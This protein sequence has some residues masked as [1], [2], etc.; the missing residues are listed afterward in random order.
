MSQ[1]QKKA[2]RSSDIDRRTFIKTVGTT[3]G[4]AGAA[5]AGSQT[6]FSP[7]GSANAVAVSG[8]LVV[9]GVSAAVGGGLV[10]YSL[11]NEPDSPDP[12]D[13]YED[14]LYNAG[15]SVATGRSTFE[16]EMQVEIAD[17]PQGESR[18][19]DSAWS[20]IRSAAAET[21]ANGGT[22][23]EAQQAAQGALER[24]TR[25]GVHNMVERWNTAV[26]GVA[27]HILT[28]VNQNVGVFTFSG[29]TNDVGLNTS[30]ISGDW[31]E[32]TEYQTDDSSYTSAIVKAPLTNLPG[33]LSE[34]DGLESETE[35][36]GIVSSDSDPHIC[37]PTKAWGASG[38]KSHGKLQVTH[39]NYATETVLNQQLYVQCLY[40]INQEYN[41]I[42]SDLST[43]VTELYNALSQ[44]ALDASDIYAPSDIVDEFAGTDKRSRLAAELAATGASVPDEVGYEAKISHPDLQA[45]ELWVDLF[46]QFSGSE[47]PIEPGTTLASGDY[48]IAYIGYTSA[49]SGEYLTQ[50]LSGDSQLQVLDLAGLE[51]QAPVESAADTAESTGEVNLG[52][53]PP[54]Q[55]QTPGDYEDTFNLVLETESSGEYTVPVS[56]V[57]TSNGNYIIPDTTSPLSGDETL[58][59]VRVVPV[60]NHQQTSEYVADPTTV[61]SSTVQNQLDAQSDFVDD[62]N[63]MESNS[64]G[65]FDLGLPSLFGIPGWLIA[66]VAGIVGYLVFVEDDGP[67]ATVLTTSDD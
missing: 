42:S 51:N 43:Y 3:V 8:A 52:S 58:V 34:I 12:N 4:A 7:V 49:A 46:P 13:V 17:K 6:A 63:N 54:D 15:V 25:I 67:G 29:T 44:G 2:G 26:L 32:V 22:E 23:T 16:E 5:Y 19:A 60:V 61:D 62:V 31:S 64:G 28:D 1:T 11:A 45:D 37:A 35:M 39:S 56:D 47:V 9:A 10:G 30:T 40:D 20:E 53:D 48:D 55:V 65:G 59:Q 36:Y 24:A 41:S 38:V 33:N 21:I 18:F 27:E 14:Q 57:T 50:I 66:G